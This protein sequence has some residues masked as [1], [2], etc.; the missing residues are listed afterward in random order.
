MQDEKNVSQLVAAEIIENGY[1]TIKNFFNQKE[2]ITF[3]ECVVD[4]FLLQAQKIGEYRSE[5]LRIEKSG[6]SNFEKFCSIYEMMEQNDK[7]ALYQV[8]KFLASSPQARALFNDKFLALTG[9]ILG[10]KN[11]R[12]LIDG[13]A[14]FINRP[15]TERLLYKWH[16]EAHYFPKRRRF[17]NIWLPLFDNKTKE[18]G[19]MS[20][21]KGSH[22]RDFPFSDYQGYNK[23]TQSKSN[24][25]VQ[26]EIPPNLLTKYKEYWCE[27]NPS[28]LVIF[29]KNMVHT[30]NQN[31]SKKYSVA[32]VARIWDP[33]DDLTLSGS[34]AA[35]PYGG[36]V[37]R[38]N[39]VVDLLD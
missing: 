26:Y 25:F 20:F 29:H 30:S 2:L 12:V 24:F 39:L 14:L 7:E 27:V 13:P 33:T 1:S 31:F 8:Q 34:I 28:D 32:V 11:N 22:K 19:T 18:N 4:F 16:S 15:N 21:K 23:D 5:A 35:T 3:E 6:R 10:S 36:N 9:S 17:I 37:G 38:P